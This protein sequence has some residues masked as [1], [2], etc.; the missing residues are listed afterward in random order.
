MH[1]TAVLQ[2]IANS[3][4]RVIAP[5]V[6]GIPVTAVPERAMAAQVVEAE[7]GW[8][9]AAPPAAEGLETREPSEAVRVDPV[10]AVRVLAV[11][12]GHRAWGVEVGAVV[13]V[14]ADEGE[15]AGE[16]GGIHE[17]DS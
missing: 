8:V 12:V 14:E 16:S 11:R 1:A 13:A 2:A 15:P 4:A 10:G 6:G 17:I 7:T 3:Q 5:A 9:I